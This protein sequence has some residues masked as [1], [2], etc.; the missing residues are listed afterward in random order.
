E[1]YPLGVR[2]HRYP[3]V[4]KLLCQ[5]LDLLVLFLDGLGYISLRRLL[6]VLL[7]GRWWLGLFFLAIARIAPY[8]YTKKNRV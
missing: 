6:R 5:L 7:F 4:F 3:L 2:L 8:T 1:H